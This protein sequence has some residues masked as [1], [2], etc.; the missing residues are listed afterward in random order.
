MTEPSTLR[1]YTGQHTNDCERVLVTLL[2]GLGPW[3]DSFC[4]IGGL[5]PRY[6]VPR[7]SP[8]VPPHVG[9]LDVDVVIDLQALTDTRAYRTLDDNF[10]RL[11]FERARNS[12]G[13]PVSWRWQRRTE[14][15][16]RIVLELLADAPNTNGGRTRPLPTSGR[17]SA[18]NIPHSS[19][20]LDLYRIA[21]VRAE[22][23]D[24]NG[25]VTEQVK[26]ADPVSFTCL[27]A[28]AFDQRF[29]QKDAYDLVYCIEY[30]PEGLDVISK[31]FI[32]EINGKHGSVIQKSLALLQKHFAQDDMTEGYRKDGP[33]AVAKFEEAY[34][35]ISGQHEDQ[36]LRRRQASDAVEQLL[37]R[38]GFLSDC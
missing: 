17:V 23:L 13:Q 33:V 37:I 36:A 31:A 28:L 3:K 4:L 15:G 2:R 21:E 10:R 16:A 8:Q 34:G 20:V 11:H 12:E 1:G 9:T 26:H 30:A 32:Q 14:H 38:I 6:L 24:G 29:E 18:L 22:L 25:I 19:I 5:T 27:K 7:R 35:I